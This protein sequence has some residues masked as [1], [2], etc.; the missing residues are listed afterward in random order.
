MFAFLISDRRNK[1][2]NVPQKRRR[3]EE[4]NSTQQNSNLKGEKKAK[5]M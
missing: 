3:E 4:R 2:K 1:S 5:A